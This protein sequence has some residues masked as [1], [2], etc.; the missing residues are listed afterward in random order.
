MNYWNIFI[1][2]TIFVLEIDQIMKCSAT[3][4]VQSW[5]LLREWPTPN[6]R[7]YTE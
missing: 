1:D 6:G 7:K 5:L 3:S 4:D 2:A